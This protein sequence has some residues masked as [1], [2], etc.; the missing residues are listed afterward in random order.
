V[1]FEVATE[2]REGETLFT[3]LFKR[4][5]EDRQIGAPFS[6]ECVDLAIRYADL[7]RLKIDIDYKNVS[8]YIRKV[9]HKVECIVKGIYHW[10]TDVEEVDVKNPENKISAVVEFAT[11]RSYVDIKYKTPTQNVSIINIDLPY[12]VQ[13][14]NGLFP[15]TPAR[16]VGLVEYPTCTLTGPKIYTFDDVSDF[17]PLSQCYHVLV[18]DATEDNLF[19]VLVANVAKN[20]LAKKV[21]VMF[22]GHRIEF[23]PKTEGSIPTGNP[24]Q[25]ID[26][27]SLYIVKYNG[28]ELKDVFTPEKRTTIPPTTPEEKQELA[29]IM[30]LKPE[31]TGNK[32]PIFALVSRVTGIHVLF[33]GTSV[34]VKP[35]PFWKNNFVGLCGTYDGQPWSDKLLPNMTLVETPQELSRAFLLNV[36]GCDKEISPIPKMEKMRQ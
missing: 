19:A 12:N 15:W 28:Q 34:T 11:D 18:K 2:V 3:P 23:I 5:E 35:S 9:L 36:N 6:K 29:Y 27:K 8:P 21:L 13:P 33:D 17:M 16:L 22:E 25:P 20:S 31:T 1:P 26:L 14:A 24:K 10:N 30:M 4:C 7:L 32:E